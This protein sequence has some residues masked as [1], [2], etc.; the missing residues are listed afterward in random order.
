MVSVPP[1]R[2]VKLTFPSREPGARRIMAG[3]LQVGV[4]LQ[5]HTRKWRAYLWARPGIV[6]RAIEIKGDTVAQIREQ[7]R[8]RLEREGPWWTCER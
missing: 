3:K 1:E 6:G 2:P 7:V 4:C 5:M 8:G